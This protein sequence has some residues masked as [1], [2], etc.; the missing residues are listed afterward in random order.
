VAGVTG[1]DDGAK[2]EHGHTAKLV[3]VN[4]HEY[5]AG[6]AFPDVSSTPL[7]VAVYVVNGLRAE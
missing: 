4:D 1:V 5:G 7:T 2:T 3:V 6:I